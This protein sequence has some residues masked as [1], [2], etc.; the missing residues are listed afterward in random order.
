MPFCREDTEAK[1]SHRSRIAAAFLS[2]RADSIV[3]LLIRD[4]VKIHS[5]VSH[6]AIISRRRVKRLA[7]EPDLDNSW[8]SFL[9]AS[10]STFFCRNR[11]SKNNL[12]AWSNGQWPSS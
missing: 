4:P 11:S 8:P 1:A 9:K 12:R 5:H 2:R 3:E 7:G 6:H 10:N